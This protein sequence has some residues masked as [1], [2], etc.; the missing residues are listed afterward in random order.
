[1]NL[2]G[3]TIERAEEVLDEIFEIAQKR[4][5][6]KLDLDS[7]SASDACHTHGWLKPKEEEIYLACLQMVIDDE[8]SRS[9]SNHDIKLMDSWK[10]EE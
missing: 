4:A 8:N 6:K 1:M 5:G 3:E 7:F 9:L 10:G 2:Y